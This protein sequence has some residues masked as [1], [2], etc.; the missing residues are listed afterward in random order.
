[1]PP[2]MSY[3]PTHGIVAPPD[4]ETF[5]LIALMTDDDGNRIPLERLPLDRKGRLLDQIL[6]AASQA[7]HFPPTHLRD[8]TSPAYVRNKRHRVQHCEVTNF[9]LEGIVSPRLFSSRPHS[10]DDL[11]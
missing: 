4:S 2:F 9:L 1:M 6:Y 11:S 10:I 5:N 7:R 8:S 3:Y